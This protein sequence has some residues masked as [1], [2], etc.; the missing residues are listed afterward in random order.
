M[1]D[2]LHDLDIPYS[3]SVFNDFLRRFGSKHGD[4]VNFPEFRS[5]VEEREASLRAV[6]KEFDIGGDGKLCRSDLSHICDRLNM[7][8]SHEEIDALIEYAD[9]NESGHVVCC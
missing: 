3:L 1:K 5:F 4:R 2:A 9:E 7:K 6:F 8:L